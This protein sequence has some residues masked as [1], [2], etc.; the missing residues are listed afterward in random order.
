MST[1]RTC[2]LCREVLNSK[3]FWDNLRIHKDCLA[4]VIEQT[5]VEAG[6]VKVK[7]KAK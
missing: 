2:N 7:E 1:A 6:E 5:I 4:A 3:P